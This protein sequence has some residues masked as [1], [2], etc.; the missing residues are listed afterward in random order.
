MFTYI[1]FPML[2]NEKDED[3][4]KIYVKVTDALKYKSPERK[5]E[6]KFLC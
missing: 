2:E 3:R 4:R 5:H 1:W 6:N